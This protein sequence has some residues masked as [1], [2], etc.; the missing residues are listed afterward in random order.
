MALATAEAVM[1]EHER[2]A[3]RNIEFALRNERAPGLAPRAALI[4]GRAA[5][6]AL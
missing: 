4:R 2:L 3:F 6:H 1:R 5:A